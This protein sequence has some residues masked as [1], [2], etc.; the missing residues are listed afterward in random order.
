MQ[1]F[2]QQILARLAKAQG[3]SS[4]RRNGIFVQALHL[5]PPEGWGDLP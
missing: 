1:A 5:P 3:G 2:Y 4:N